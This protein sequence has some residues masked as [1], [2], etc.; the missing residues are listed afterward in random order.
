MLSLKEEAARACGPLLL[1]FMHALSVA[2]PVFS[3]IMCESCPM[4]LEIL[5]AE[6][7]VAR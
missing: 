2:M 1:L 3:G 7:V 5:G 4:V 6:A